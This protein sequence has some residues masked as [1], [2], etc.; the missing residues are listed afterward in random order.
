MPRIPAFEASMAPI[1]NGKW[2]T[3]GMF[4]FFASSATA[5]KASR[6]GSARFVGVGDGILL[7]SFLA[8]SGQPGPGSRDVRP[9]ERAG[10]N[11]PLPREQ[12]TQITTHVPDPRDAIGKKQR[13]KNLLAPGRISIYAGKVDV[14]V[15]KSGDQK[16]SGGIDNA[17]TLRK[18]DAGRSSHRSDA[19]AFDQ[20]GLVP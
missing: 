14:H 8:P 16:L 15:P 10:F 9:K 13:Q 1:S 12:G 18:L 3:K 11:I 2:P 19:A 4:C 7:G 6:E 5:K 20:Y 17:G